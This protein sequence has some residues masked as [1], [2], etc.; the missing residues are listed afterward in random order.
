MEE[1]GGGEDREQPRR[2][3]RKEKEWEEGEWYMQ[4]GKAGLILTLLRMHLMQGLFL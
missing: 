2:E 4:C 1:G 3:E